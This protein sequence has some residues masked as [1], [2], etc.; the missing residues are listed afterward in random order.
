VELRLY[1]GG[2]TAG[3]IASHTTACTPDGT[4]QLTLPLKM[5]FDFGTWQS[6]EIQ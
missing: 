4:F 3:V 1:A 5:K 6:T 2:S